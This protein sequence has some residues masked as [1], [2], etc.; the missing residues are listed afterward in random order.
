M[1]FYIYRA[2]TPEGKVSRS[3]GY[4]VSLDD[5][6]DDLDRRGDTLFSCYASP[7]PLEWVG[8][9]L[10]GQLGAAEVLDFC[11][12][13]AQYLEAGADLPMAWIALPGPGGWRLVRLVRQPGAAGMGGQRAGGQSGRG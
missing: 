10:G 1:P 5:L 2:I 7:A 13:V 6:V 9:L 8:Q 4:F 11:Q 12:F 3:S